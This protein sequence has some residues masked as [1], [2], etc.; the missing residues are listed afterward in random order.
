MSKFE[1]GSYGSLTGVSLIGKVQQAERFSLGELF[2][3]CQL[4]IPGESILSVN[5]RIQEILK[6]ELPNGDHQLRLGCEFITT[7]SL[8]RHSSK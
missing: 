8:L 2:K 3:D 6:I 7:N 4:E 5:L 1:D